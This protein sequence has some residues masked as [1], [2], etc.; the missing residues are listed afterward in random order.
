MLSLYVNGEKFGSSLATLP[1]ASTGSHFAIGRH[2]SVGFAGWGVNGV[3]DEVA[4]WNRALSEGEIKNLYKRGASQ[5]SFQVRSCDDSACLGESWQ[6]D[7]GNHTSTLSASSENTPGKAELDFSSLSSM[8]VPSNRY[9]QYKL[10]LESDSSILDLP[11]VDA[12][13][14]APVLCKSGVSTINFGKAIDFNSLSSIKIKYG[15]SG[16]ASGV[17]LLVSGDNSSWQYYDGNSWVTSDNSWGE[18]NTEE[19]IQSGLE[20]LELEEK[21][22]IKALLNSDGTSPCEVSSVNIT[23]R[24]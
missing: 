2:G 6:G 13:K 15:A 7:L 20:T 4:V 21:L 14:A 24:F 19:Q 22:Y 17:R 16:C 9:F 5:V 12:I 18:A 23:G 3:I 11:S 10:I 1:P 8:N